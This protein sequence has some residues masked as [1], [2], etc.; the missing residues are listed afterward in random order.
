[1]LVASMP[2]RIARSTA[3]LKAS[4]VPKIA[5]AVR[6][7]DIRT[8]VTRTAVTVRLWISEATKP[9]K[10]KGLHHEDEEDEQRPH[11]LLQ[12]HLVPGT[13]FTEDDLVFGEQRHRQV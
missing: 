2:I 4:R 6:N 12:R 3:W 7:S 13:I 9:A 11:A 5:L 8:G 10:R 1:M